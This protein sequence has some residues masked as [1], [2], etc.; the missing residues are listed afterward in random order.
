MKE[1]L[2]DNYQKIL[3]KMMMNK[4][5]GASFADSVLNGTEKGRDYLVMT[6]TTHTVQR[7]A[8]GLRLLYIRTYHDG[9]CLFPEDM[10]FDLRKD[11]TRQRIWRKKCRKKLYEGAYLLEHW[12]TEQM[13]KEYRQFS[14]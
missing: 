10:L 1:I 3:V 8:Y 13:K 11:P 4:Y 6:C 9:Y 2:G 5:D 12:T 14:D 7:G